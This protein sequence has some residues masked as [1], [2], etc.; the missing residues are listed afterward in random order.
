M[1]GPLA[2]LGAGLDLGAHGVVVD[3]GEHDPDALLVHGTAERTRREDGAEAAID[4]VERP[5]EGHVEWLEER[6]ERRLPGEHRPVDVVRH[7]GVTEDGPVAAPAHFSDEREVLITTA[8]VDPHLAVD[9]AADAMLDGLGCEESRCGHD[10]VFGNL[11]ARVR[12]N[13]VGA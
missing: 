5:R 8:W 6:V 10:Q 7:D 1:A 11:A 3:V 2:L 9:D 4:P 12:T 13:K